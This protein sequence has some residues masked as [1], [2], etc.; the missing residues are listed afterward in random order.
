MLFRSQK[1]LRKRSMRDDHLSV[2]T[3]KEGDGAGSKEREF[4]IDFAA[5]HY[6]PE[7]RFPELENGLF[8]AGM[9]ALPFREE[10]IVP[11]TME[12][13]TVATSSTCIEFVRNYLGI[14]EA[15]YVALNR[16]R[17]NAVAIGKARC[18][19]ISLGYVADM[20]VLIA[21]LYQSSY[22][23]DIWR[24][25]SNR[26]PL[27]NTPKRSREEALA[28]MFE[29]PAPVKDVP[30][31]LSIALLSFCIEFT[32]FHELGHLVNGHLTSGNSA[33]A[34]MATIDDRDRLLTRRALE[35]DADAFAVQRCLEWAKLRSDTL[36]SNFEF[37]KGNQ[38]SWITMITA[39]FLVV[40]AM[41]RK[42]DKT[43][44]DYNSFTH[45]PPYIRGFEVMAVVNRV[46][47]RWQAEKGLVLPVD[48]ANTIV[49]IR[50][51]IEAAIA[52]VGDSGWNQAAHDRWMSVIIQHDT[53]L[54]ARWA[55]L[56]PQL[57]RRKLGRFNNLAAAQEPPA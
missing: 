22:F 25:G 9:A 12:A 2:H 20:V 16:A 44:P 37:L 14:D 8:N 50:G 52:D 39:M 54:L 38:N 24:S 51:C 15:L 4:T 43:F 29:T 32:A 28:W 5:R 45:P 3:P 57:D 55:K 21:H 19:V 23:Q 36:D 40:V 27:T 13:R 30:A 56:R 7:D 53:A 47:E 49:R 48:W 1:A 17:S 41:D 10:E 35:M 42:P 6:F 26:G 33:I 46:F 31:P 18:F 11:M 34:E